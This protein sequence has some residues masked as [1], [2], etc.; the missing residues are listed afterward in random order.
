MT[1][2]LAL[3]SIKA[4]GGTASRTLAD[5]CA[6]IVNVRD[7]G[8]T[9]DGSTDDYAAIRAALDAALGPV[10]SPH[11]NAV[12][13]T[14]RPVWFPRGNYQT[15]GYFHLPKVQGGHIFGDGSG[16]TRIAYTG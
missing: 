8:A 10:S 12:K 1:T 14:N 7:Y 6:D 15:T 5:R 9:G 16:A 13:F 4:T 2:N 11:G 3:A